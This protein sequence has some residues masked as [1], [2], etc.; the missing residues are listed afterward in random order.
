MQAD[1]NDPQS[2]NRYAY[3]RNN[4]G[5]LIDPFGLLPE[6]LSRSNPHDPHNGFQC[7]VDGALTPCTMALSL[8]AIG[9][10][11]VCPQNDCS[12]W[13]L[14]TNVYG[15]DV[16]L[17]TSPLGSPTNPAFTAGCNGNTCILSVMFPAMSRSAAS[18][19]TALSIIKGT[20]DFA[21]GAGDCLTGR[22]IPFVHTSAT[23]WARSL[24]GADSVVNKNSIS[25]AGGEI[26]GGV[27]GTAL[28]SAGG[29]TAAAIADG[30]NGAL[31]GRGVNTVF[32]SS[33]LRFGWAWKG[34]AT[35]GRNVIRLGIGAARGTSW[36]SHV[37]F[38]SRWI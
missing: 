27:V 35:A 8:S 9:S 22:C 31:F 37:V 23:E 34:S 1:I 24:N 4:P 2:S 32:N 10:S 28:L 6:G 38:W 12:I 3:V 36:W 14:T 18:S 19:W 5:N 20:S 26:T 25:Y 15:N 16:F 11:G 29:A 7:E 13:K 33:G 17:N 30:K 21:A